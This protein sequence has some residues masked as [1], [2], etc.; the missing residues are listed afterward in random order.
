MAERFLSL[1][2]IDPCFAHGKGPGFDPGS[3]R[4][5]S[6]VFQSGRDTGLSARSLDVCVLLP[7]HVNDPRAV[8]NQRRV[9]GAFP[10]FGKVNRSS[11]LHSDSFK[12]P[13]HF[14]TQS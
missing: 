5:F 12:A 10:H 11:P 3:T 8:E 2:L 9:Q 14:L 4:G 1:T 6:A 13:N 7:A